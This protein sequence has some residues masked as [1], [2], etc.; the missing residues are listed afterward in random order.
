MFHIVRCHSVG[1]QSERSE[2]MDW[3]H[4]FERLRNHLSPANGKIQNK[5]MTGGRVVECR[6][7]L[8]SCTDS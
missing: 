4:Y 2:K 5:I 3:F 8:V 7:A 1:K 6:R